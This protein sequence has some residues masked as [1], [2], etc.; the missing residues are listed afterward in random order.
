MILCQLIFSE[1]KAPLFI[2]LFKFFLNIHGFVGS[3]QSRGFSLEGETIYEAD[4][5]R[6]MEEV[7]TYA[8]FFLGVIELHEDDTKMDAQETREEEVMHDD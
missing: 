6:G 4:M 7:F 8:G 2:Y 1:L 5:R 3:V